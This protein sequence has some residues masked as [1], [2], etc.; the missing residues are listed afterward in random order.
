MAEKKGRFYAVSTGVGDPELLTLKALRILKDTKALAYPVSPEGQTTALNIIKPLVDLSGKQL[1]DLQT[2]M[3]RDKEELE[4]AHMRQVK[5]LEEVL[6]RGEDVAMISLGDVSLYSTAA[7]V[8]EKLTFQ[9]YDCEMIPGVTSACAAACALKTSLADMKEAV[10]I[11]PAA[12][13]NMDQALSLEGTKVLMKSGQA[14]SGVLASIRER[15]MEAETSLVANCGMIDE[16]CFQDIQ[17]IG[18]MPGYFTTIL[19]KDKGK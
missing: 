17:E 4:H 16:R 8:V 6:C 13:G 9:G 1:I 5:Q 15:G 19:V 10:H 7:Y 12:Y 3:S 11:I 2:V 18:E 14:L